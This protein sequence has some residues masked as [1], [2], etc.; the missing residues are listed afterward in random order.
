[1]MVIVVFTS[2]KG[3]PYFAELSNVN[4]KNRAFCF[5]SFSYSG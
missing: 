3:L 1:M 4:R 2:V 5:C